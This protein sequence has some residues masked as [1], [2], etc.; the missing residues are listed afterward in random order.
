MPCIPGLFLVPSLFFGY[1]RQIK[2]R[3]DVA[4]I[5]NTGR[6]RMHPNGG[7]VSSNFIVLAPCRE[8]ITDFRN[9]AQTRAF[10]YADVLIKGWIRL[11]NSGADVTGPIPINNL[12]E[13]AILQLIQRNN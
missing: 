7:C 2:L 6:A 3:I 10:C 5:F 13:C 9:G 12:S 1:H 8:D 4:R 11:M